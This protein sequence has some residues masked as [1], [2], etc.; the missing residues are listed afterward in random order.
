MKRIVVIVT[1]L[2]LV[3]GVQAQPTTDPRCIAFMGL[4]LEGHADTLRLRLKDLQ[5]TEW[6]GSEDGE[7][8]YFRG[9]YYGIRSKVIISVMPLSV[10]V[11]QAYVTIG[12]YRSKN[13]LS[14]NL[15]YIK[16]KLEQDCGP[17]T[18][19]D[20]GWYYIDDFGSVK[21][22]VVDNDDGTRDIRVL[23]CTTA[24]FYKDAL[25][26]GLRGN[27]QEIITENPLS[28]NPVERYLEN[29][30]MDNPDLVNRQYNDY[31]YLIRAEMTE[32]Q[33]HSLVEFSYD[34]QYRLIRRTLTN[35]TA[36]IRYVNEYTY[37][38]ED[39]ILT[40]NQKVYD[41][42]GTCIMTL[43]IRNNY[44]TRDEN[45]NWTSNSI[46]LTYWEKG[47]ASQQSTA[48][49]KRTISYWE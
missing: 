22:S 13:L 1:L 17:L 24:P 36:G 12:P 41:K 26:I 4:P 47:G 34:D 40:Q 2:M 5:F 11:N 44:L 15:L 30:Q 37:T 35:A 21:L 14:R 31:G 10:L 39:E 20:G 28:E 9:N 6:G 27:V 3:I 43:N 48:M 18:E 42:T 16:Y 19:R 49:Q 38:D 29:G 45:G 7:D 32:Q 46:S 25:C 8:I 23:Y 33:G